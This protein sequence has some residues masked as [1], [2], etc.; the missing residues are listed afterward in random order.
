[1]RFVELG[2]AQLTLTLPSPTKWARV[3]KKI[4]WIEHSP[5]PSPLGEGRGEGNFISL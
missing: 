2:T 1:M 5:S 4:R 3:K